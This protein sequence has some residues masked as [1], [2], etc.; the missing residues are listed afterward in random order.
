VSITPDDGV[1]LMG[2]L[3]LPPGPGP[4]PA[5]VLVH[6]S[7]DQSAIESFHAPDF[8]APNGVATLV[9]DK[10][11]TGR[12]AGTYT[13]DFERLAA[14]VVSA[15]DTIA[16]RPEIDPRRIGLVGYSQG[17]WVAPLAASMSRRVHF[18]VVGYGMVE[19]PAVEVRLETLQILRDRGVSEED[20]QA[21]RV[22]TDAAVAVVAS[23]FDDGWERLDR[24]EREYR[25]ETWFS[26]LRGTVVGK[27][28]NLPKVVVRAVGP[29]RLPPGLDWY[30]TSTPVLRRLEVPSVW[31]LGAE[32]RSAPNTLTIPTLCGLAS[33]G[34]PISVHLF[35]GAAHGMLRTE[36][37][38]GRR[39]A[40]G[41]VPDYFRTEVAVVRGLAG[42]ERI[43][44]NRRDPCEPGA[45]ERGQ[46]PVADRGAR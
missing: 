2:R 14:D 38:G 4:H 39:T 28:V 23:G 30:Y 10:R 11:G 3:D 12:S 7:G 15:V 17:G 42:L 43:R 25:K 18:V 27:L 29:R 6:G 36:S 37:R 33:D 31:L 32:D 1:T 26:E 22:L 21:A 9:F 46:L 44:G 20:L 24:L 8:F 19:S 40:T 34:R 41:Y 16:E 5:V 45:S 13:F 35:E